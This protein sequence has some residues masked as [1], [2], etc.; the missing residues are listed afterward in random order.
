[1]AAGRCAGGRG[2]DQVDVLVA[3]AAVAE[4]ATPPWRGPPL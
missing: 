4:V 2:L 1:V 3:D